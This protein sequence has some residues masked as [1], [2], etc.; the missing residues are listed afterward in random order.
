M[1]LQAEEINEVMQDATTS[2]A[3]SLSCEIWVIP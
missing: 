1:L 2:N 3:L